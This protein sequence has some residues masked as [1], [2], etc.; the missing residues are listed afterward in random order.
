MGE[1]EAAAEENP[2]KPL[3]CGTSPLR[4]RTDRQLR[5]PARKM[6]AATVK[7]G[8]L[9]A[10]CGECKGTSKPRSRSC[11]MA[12]NALRMSGKAADFLH[13][14]IDENVT[15]RDLG[16]TSV[17]QLTERAAAAA[18]G[19]GIRIKETKPDLGSIAAVI[20]EAIAHQD[21]GR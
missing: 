15:G 2:G 3:L 19:K 6:P 14:W 16:W 12:Q 5:Q 20:F 18:A 13:R 7:D 1:G 11:A 21:G 17:E 9:F 4:F 8:G 10:F